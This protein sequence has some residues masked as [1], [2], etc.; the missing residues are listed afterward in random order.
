[1]RPLLD[2]A[3]KDDLAAGKTVLG[4]GEARRDRGRGEDDGARL[5]TVE[6]DDEVLVAPYR[7]E[8]ARWVGDTFKDPAG[9]APAQ[10]GALEAG[11]SIEIGRSHSSQT[12]ISTAVAATGDRGEMT[13]YSPCGSPAADRPLANSVRSGRNQP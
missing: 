13:G 5:R 12:G 11:M 10:T 9:V 2:D 3:E 1:M 8:K 6:L 4:G 7:N